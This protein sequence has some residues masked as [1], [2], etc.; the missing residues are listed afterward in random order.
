[1]PNIGLALVICN[2][3]DD[4]QKVVRSLLKWGL[5]PICC[6]TVQES[7]T[8]LFQKAFKVILCS[9]SLSDGDFQTVLTEIKKSLDHP[10]VIVLSRVDEWDSYLKALGAGAFD[11]IV[12]P[13]NPEE[14]ERIIWSALTENILTEK[15]AQ[16]VA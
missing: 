14:T 12:C 9:D 6:S 16:A 5:S 7:R 11:T 13:P 3:E 8:Q 4:R 2:Q 15:A 10:P 1:M